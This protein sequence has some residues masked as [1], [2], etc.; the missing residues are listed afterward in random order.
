MQRQQHHH[1]YEW[2]LAV[3]GVGTTLSTCFAFHGKEGK[4]V[5]EKKPNSPFNCILYFLKSTLLYLQK[6]LV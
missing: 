3:V 4:T 5:G 6:V 2:S 1:H